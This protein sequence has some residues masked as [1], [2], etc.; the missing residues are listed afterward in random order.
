M[1]TDETIT[2][3]TITQEHL[4]LLNAFLL[5][6]VPTFK[7]TRQ[8]QAKC[9]TDAVTK[10]AWDLLDRKPKAQWSDGDVEFVSQLYQNF[11][12]GL[13]GVRIFLNEVQAVANVRSR[14]AHLDGIDKDVKERCAA[15]R[16]RAFA[17]R[18]SPAKPKRG[19]PRLT[20]EQKMIRSFRAM[21][22]DWS[23]VKMNLTAS[24]QTGLCKL[25]A[26]Q[27]ETLLTEEMAAEQRG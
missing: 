1:K 18:E 3:E 23:I 6:V 20:P 12:D 27:I 19:A 7:R 21:K 5:G 17:I 22:L 2:M 4:D 8:E 13:T 24:A 26:S 16:K 15:D 9:A 11:R 25:T 14:A 10:I